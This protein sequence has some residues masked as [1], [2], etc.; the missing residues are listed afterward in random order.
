MLRSLYLSN[1]VT[2]MPTL[3]LVI[4][5]LYNDAKEWQSVYLS[6][7]LNSFFVVWWKYLCLILI[8]DSGIFEYWRWII[9]III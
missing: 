5:L 3:S 7:Y 1:L 2:C 4:I 9:H 6:Y 8:E